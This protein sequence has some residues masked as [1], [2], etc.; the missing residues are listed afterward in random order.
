M[1]RGDGTGPFG[2]GPRTGRGFG[3]CSGYPHPGYVVPG[4][5]GAYGY[6]RGWRHRNWFYATGLPGWARAGF[7]PPYPSPY[8]GAPSV[9]QEKEMLNRAAENIKAELEQIEKRLK[10]LNEQ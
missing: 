8:S 5:L 7:Y 4:G 1:P 9:E 10:E 6:G 3:Y 2:A